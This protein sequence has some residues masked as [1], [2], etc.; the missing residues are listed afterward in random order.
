MYKLCFFVPEAAAETVKEAV[1]EVGAGRIGNYDKCCWQVKGTGQFRPLAGSSPHLGEHGRV[2]K[3][4]EFMDTD[5][6]TVQKDDIV[7][8]VAKLMEWRKITSVR[9]RET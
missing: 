2:E 7:E 9:S 8:L 3:V 4:E 6:F 1:F 5:L